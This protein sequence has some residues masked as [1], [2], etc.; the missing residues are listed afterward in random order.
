MTQLIE[1]R[2]SADG[3]TIEQQTDRIIKAL[4]VAGLELVKRSQPYSNRN[5]SD[6]RVYLSF[7]AKE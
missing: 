5:S 4:E 6:K 2:V 1:L 7:V 3:K